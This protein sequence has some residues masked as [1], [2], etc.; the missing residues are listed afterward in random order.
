MPHKIRNFATILVQSGC[1]KRKAGHPAPLESSIF[2]CKEQ[3]SQAI[4]F[5]LVFNNNNNLKIVEYTAPAC[6]ATGAMIGTFC[7]LLADS[8]S[9]VATMW[10]LPFTAG[11]YIVTVSVIPELSELEASRD[12]AMFVGVALMVWWNNFNSRIYTMLIA[13]SIINQL[14]VCI[15]N[16]RVYYLWCMRSAYVSTAKNN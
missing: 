15:D 13:N 3:D 2:K 6:T 4:A 5:S 11:S 9:S 7:G 8:F 16:R 12:L 14:C 1:P 10:I